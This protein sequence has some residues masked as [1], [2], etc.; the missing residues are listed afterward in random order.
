M[1]YMGKKF[2]NDKKILPLKHF[3]DEELK[4]IENM[5]IKKINSPATTSAGRLFD[6][7]ASIIDLRQRVNYEAQ[8]AMEL[9]FLT[10]DSNSNENY[11]F[12]ITEDNSGA[13]NYIIDWEPMIQEIL[14]DKLNKLSLNLL[15]IKFHNTLS[16]IILS[17]AKI[18]GEEKVALSGG[19]FQN[20]YL[21]ER[22]VNLLEKENFKPY[23]H[24]RVPPN[25]GGISLGQVIYS[26]F[27]YNFK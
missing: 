2:F 16:Q 13:N 8:A 5:L 22:T 7:V 20:R 4:V 18:V 14:I 9:E 6:A 21:L 11:D 1:K 25:D 27:N 23:W 24:Q 3:S 15:S 19:C 12:Q 17:V 10:S 26:S